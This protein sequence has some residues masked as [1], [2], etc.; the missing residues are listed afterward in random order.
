MKLRTMDT[1]NLYPKVSRTHLYHVLFPRIQRHFGPSKA[2][3]VQFIITLVVELF[4]AIFVTVNDEIFENL[5]GIP[6][7]CS[8][9]VIIANCYLAAF[10]EWVVDHL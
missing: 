7:G 10:D 4:A 5:D 9:A 6:T 1:V 8:P 3:L 2:K